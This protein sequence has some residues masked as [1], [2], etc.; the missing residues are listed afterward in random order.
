MRQVRLLA[1]AIGLAVVGGSVL[2]L[3]LVFGTSAASATTRLRSGSLHAHLTSRGPAGA[4]PS[5]LALAG[6]NVTAAVVGTLA[7]LSLA[8]II[9]TLIRRRITTA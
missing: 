7:V 2:A 6:A 1:S 5:D 9:V 3:A 4:A 8:F